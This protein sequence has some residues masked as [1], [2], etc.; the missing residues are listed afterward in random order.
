MKVA[1]EKLGKY[2]PKMDKVDST[3][4]PEAYSKF[5]AKSIKSVATL[6]FT[7]ERKSMSTVVKGL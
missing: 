1:A 4:E 6:D 5:L 3:K 2:D 7:S